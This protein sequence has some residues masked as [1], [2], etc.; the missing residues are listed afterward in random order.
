MKFL[1]IQVNQEQSIKKDI[2]EIPL[3]NPKKLYQMGDTE[4]LRKKLRHHSGIRGREILNISKMDQVQSI[5]KDIPETAVRDWNYQM[6]IQNTSTKKL[7]TSFKDKEGNEILNIQV[8][9]K[10]SI[11]K[12]FRIPLCRLRNYKWRYR[13]H[14]R[15]KLRH[16][17]RIKKGKDNS[18]YPSE[19]G[20]VDKEN[21]P[22]YRFVETKNYQMVIQN[23]IYEKLRHHSG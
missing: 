10:Q 22:E 20:T 3:W 13:T 18:K 6:V 5:K 11:R 9:Q 12:T 17:S 23:N 16:H 21:I 2:P 1:N 19:P 4:H 15:K 7:K 8:N 14:L